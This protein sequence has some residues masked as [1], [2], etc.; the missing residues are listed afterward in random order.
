M[1]EDKDHVTVARAA[2]ATGELLLHLSEVPYSEVEGVASAQ[3]RLV[4]DGE[5]DLA[6]EFSVST[7]SGLT[8]E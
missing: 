4:Q 7:L 2:L 5:L 6:T 1:S 8:G 3:I